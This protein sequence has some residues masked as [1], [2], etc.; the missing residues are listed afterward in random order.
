MI[1]PKEYKIAFI[2][3][4]G[5]FIWVFM[6]FGF[7]NAP[8]TYQQVVNMTFKYYLGMSMKLFMYNFKLEHPFNK[9]T[10]ML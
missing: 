6:P 10:I 2:T 5:T 8:P 4:W 7:Q 9:V 1:A 3:D